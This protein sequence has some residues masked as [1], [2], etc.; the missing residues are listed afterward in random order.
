MTR[1][2]WASRRLRISA[3]PW[4]STKTRRCEN[5]PIR[6]MKRE[7]SKN[8]SS[9]DTAVDF[10]VKKAY[11]IHHTALC[12]HLLM[13]SLG[14]RPHYILLSPFRC[15][16]LVHMFAEF[17]QV[18][19]Q[20]N[21]NRPYQPLNGREVLF[22]TPQRVALVSVHLAMWLR[23]AGNRETS[24]NVQASD[25]IYLV[26]EPNQTFRQRFLLARRFIRQ[27]CVIIYSL[28]LSSLSEYQGGQKMFKGGLVCLCFSRKQ[29]KIQQTLYCYSYLHH[30]PNMDT[31]HIICPIWILF[32]Y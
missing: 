24:L 10:V 20:G 6:S 15:N 3:H 18:D 21:T 23:K 9:S 13:H 22:V 19:E 27:L 17:I 8:A 30:M 32:R 1:L 16:L 7:Y 2:S 25:Q 26:H 5:I 29:C 31:V 11:K 12:L 14:L 4:R 28:R